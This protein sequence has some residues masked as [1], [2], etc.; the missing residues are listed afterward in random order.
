[1]NSH[2]CPTNERDPG[3][4]ILDWG[5]NDLRSK[6]TPKDIAEVIADLGKSMKTNANEV[7]ISGLVTS[8]DQWHNKTMDVGRF[9]YVDN[10]NIEPEYH[11]NRTR[12][13]LNREG[14][15]ILANNFLYALG[16]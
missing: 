7:I 13:H 5:T 15:R 6:D 14:T 10:T 12:I 8:G 9:S 1:M 16:Y 4:I 3:K 2:V 11:L